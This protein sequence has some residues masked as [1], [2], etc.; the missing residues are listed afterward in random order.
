LAALFAA[1]I[2]S[3]VVRNLPCT[4]GARTANKGR[5]RRACATWCPPVPCPRSRA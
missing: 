5:P 3:V 2:E 4:R 1:R